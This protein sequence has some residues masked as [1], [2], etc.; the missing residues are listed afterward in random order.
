MGTSENVNRVGHP[1]G[2]RTAAEVE[3]ALHAGPNGHR[4]VRVLVVSP[5]RFYREGLASILGREDRIDVI[6]TAADPWSAGELYGPRT[7]LD[8]VLLDEAIGLECLAVTSRTWPGTNVVVIAVGNQPPE[9]LTW[10]EAGIAGFVTREQSLDD[11]RAAVLGAGVGEVPCA[12]HLAG[13]LLRRVGSLA[14]G[15][16]PPPLSER[17]TSREREIAAL[18][19]RGLANKQI[20]SQLQIELPTVKNHVH[21]ILEKLH[22]TRRGEAA[23]QLRRTGL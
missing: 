8:V 10:A 6:G 1:G 23:A 19:E 15:Q 7:S 5:V 14:A 4:R 12:P 16:A 11:L 22:V 21:N 9:V 13:A 3:H 2:D 17:L 18:L 20:A